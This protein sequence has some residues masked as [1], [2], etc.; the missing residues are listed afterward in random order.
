[1]QCKCYLDLLIS[2]WCRKCY[3][4]GGGGGGG[5]GGGDYRGKQRSDKQEAESGKERGE[6]MGKRECE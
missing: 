3:S 2:R 5:G 4:T 1:M 6:S